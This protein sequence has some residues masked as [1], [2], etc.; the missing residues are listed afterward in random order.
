MSKLP[1]S[2]RQIEL[3]VASAKDYV[4]PSD[5]LRPRVIEAARSRYGFVMNS[6]RVLQVAAIVML[7]VLL[8]IPLQQRLEDWRNAAFAPSTDEMEMQAQAYAEQPAV[9]HNWGLV[10]AYKNLKQQQHVKISGGM[11]HSRFSE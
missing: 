6:Q 11:T 3:M 4:A 10:E 5:N 7:C 9:G 8:T 2:L 1:D